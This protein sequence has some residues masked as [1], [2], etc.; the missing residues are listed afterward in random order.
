MIMQADRVVRR[1]HR[2]E[3]A[4]RQ[5]GLGKFREALGRQGEVTGQNMTGDCLDHGV[6]E[7]LPINAGAG[8]AVGVVVRCVQRMGAGRLNPIEQLV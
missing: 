4:G 7:Q 6:A 3:F 5:L 1:C 8:I 2:T